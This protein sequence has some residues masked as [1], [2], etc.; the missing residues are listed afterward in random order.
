[1]H[2]AEF[3]NILHEKENIEEGDTLSKYSVA[4]SG[5]LYAAFI[6]FTTWSRVKPI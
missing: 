5:L 2:L 1:M 4:R 3:P 6:A